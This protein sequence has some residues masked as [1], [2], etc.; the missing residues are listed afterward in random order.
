MRDFLLFGL[1]Q[2]LRQLSK[3]G[4]DPLRL[5]ARRHLATPKP[6]K[7]FFFEIHVGKGL[8]VRVFDR[9]AAIQLLD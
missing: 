7:R 9:E 6:A 4:G 2:Q 8:S 5:V 3:D 1:A